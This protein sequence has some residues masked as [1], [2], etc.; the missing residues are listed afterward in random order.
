MRQNQNILAGDLCV[1][2]AMAL[3]GTYSLFLRFAPS[4]PTL[5]FLFGFQAIGFVAFAA[6]NKGLGAVPASMRKWMALLVISAL[7]N[8]L[9]LFSGFRL[10]SV[11]NI[12]FSHQTV[13]IF[14]LFLAP[15]VLQERTRQEEWLSLGIA[16]VGLAFLYM[17]KPDSSVTGND[18]AGISLGI[19][20]GLFYALVLLMYRVLFKGDAAGSMNIARINT[21][22]YG[23]STFVLAPI[24]FCSEKIDFTLQNAAVVGSFGVL[25]AVVATILHLMGIARTRILHASILGKSEPLFAVLYA[26]IFLHEIPS[27]M[28][29]LGGTLIISSAF[30]LV[31]KGNVES[32]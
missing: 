9:A 4:I 13:S 8:D 19:A 26:A 18:I 22:R 5:E 32:R 3:F 25:F 28:T 24:L 29:L 14:L 21:W 6:A 15:W 27:G 2:S 11:A 12:A 31:L 16:G 17:A 23:V 30:F 7:A 1:L 20:S 10:T